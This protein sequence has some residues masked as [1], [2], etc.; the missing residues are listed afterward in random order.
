M[1][2]NKIKKSVGELLHAQK[3]IVLENQCKDLGKVL[4]KKVST[5]PNQ[6]AFIAFFCEREHRFKGEH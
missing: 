4:G 3:K 1:I 5:L 6:E 2:K